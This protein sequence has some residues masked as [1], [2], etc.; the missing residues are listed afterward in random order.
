MAFDL[1]VVEG[2]SVNTKNEAMKSFERSELKARHVL[3]LRRNHPES[4]SFVQADPGYCYSPFT[5]RH[6]F[7]V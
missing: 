2:S 4:L 6:A 1:H 7:C 5:S 3:S